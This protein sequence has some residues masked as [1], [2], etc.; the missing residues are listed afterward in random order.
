MVTKQKVTRV[1]AIFYINY[2]YIHF[3]QILAFFLKISQP[4]LCF[5]DYII[6]MYSESNNKN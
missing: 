3:Q 2:L 6:G 5:S 4:V 1:I